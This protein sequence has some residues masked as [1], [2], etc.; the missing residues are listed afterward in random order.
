MGRDHVD[1]P[2]RGERCDAKDDEVGNEIGALSSDSSRPGIKTCFPTGKGEDG[3]AKS[4][5]NEVTEG[6]SCRDART[7]EK[8]GNSD[9]PDSATENREVH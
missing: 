1:N 5:G 8:K 6:G 4:G 9:S 2:M 3:G 7:S